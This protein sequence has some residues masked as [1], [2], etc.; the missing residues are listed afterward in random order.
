M[1]GVTGTNGKTTTTHLI[2]YFLTECKKNTALI[3]TLYSRWNGFK[4]TSIHTTPFSPELQAQLSQAV[5]D[6][7]EYCVIEVSSHALVQGRVKGCGFNVSIF[8]NLTQDHLDFHKNL[9]NYF[10]AKQL[11]FS[12]EYLQGKAVVNIDDSYGERLIQ[13]LG[14]QKVYSYSIENT[15][16]DFHTNNLNYKHDRIEGILKTPGGNF[17]FQSPLVGKFNLS[18]LLAAIATL[19]HLNIDLETVIN[20]LPQFP[21]VP[22]R[23]EKIEVSEVQDL[24]LIHI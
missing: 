22:G 12:P 21:G 8:T 11:L 10:L 5:I 7:N 9:E 18:N 17:E 16:P 24:S 13:Y 3:G 4:Q 6:K 1:I 15:M 2:E 23:V 19:F 14:P 20:K